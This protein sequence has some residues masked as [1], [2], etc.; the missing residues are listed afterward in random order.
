M[1]RFYIL[2]AAAAALVGC[3]VEG[4][5]MPSINVEAKD[6][7]TL[8][9]NIADDTRVAIS[10]DKFTEVSWLAG[11]AVK[12]S[13]E[14][15]ASATLYA[16]SAGK[17]VRFVGEGEAKAEVDNYYAVYGRTGSYSL[18]GSVVT[19]NYAE[20]YGGAASAA[21]LLVGKAEGVSAAD[22]SMSFSPANALLRVSVSGVSAISK[23]EF[24]ALD[25]SS[26]AT[27]YSYNIAT[28][29]VAHTATGSVIEVNAPSASGF[30]ISLP[31]D[32]DMP[33][34]VV[35]LTDANGNVCTKA[36]S[37]KI[38]AKGTTTRVDFEWTTPSVTLGAKSSYSYYL[39]DGNNGANANKFTDPTTIYFSTGVNGESCDSSYANVQDAVIEDLGYEIDG[40]DYT[41]SAGQVT[42]N[43]AN[44][45][46][47]MNSSVSPS[48]DK[49]LGNKT[50]IK[51]FIKVNGKKV[52]STNTVWLTGLP[53]N[54][55]FEDGSLS[56][57]AADGW[58]ANGTLNMT[59]RTLVA[60]RTSTLVL[61]VKRAGVKESGF[62]VSPKFY[63]PSNIN[64]QASIHRSAYFLYW[65]GAQ[66]RTGYVG[67]VANT[68][69]SNTSSVTYTSRSTTGDTIYGSGEWL[70]A[71]TIS[72][73][74][75]YI[76]IDSD[77]GDFSSTAHHY[78][79]HEAHFRY[80]Q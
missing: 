11:D 19:L 30:F 45:T 51:A 36:Y 55:D 72:P 38:F 44:N 9:A 37:A 78:F 67:A 24:Y 31:A 5:N 61:Q 35:R 52:Y 48:Y 53:Y 46:F 4:D 57:Y 58:T 71:F 22:L 23:A 26:F 25:G 64:V 18:S 33:N 41:H 74:A 49:T 6:K 65:G 2:V 50:A 12:L 10:G 3:S 27:S 68:T 59:S 34:Y 1:K 66:T 73:S 13:S 39:A 17:S 62:I 54:Y 79:L 63:M 77:E 56:Q 42:W 69:T 15:G 70:T 8:M 40:V 7:F 16:E 21:A 20:Q 43:K 80:A 47:V 75:P 29:E 14:A 60:G 32:L 76:S 28:D